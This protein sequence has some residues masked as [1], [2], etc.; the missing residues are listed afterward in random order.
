MKRN[1]EE[2]SSSDEDFGPVP[3]G[4]AGEQGSEKPPVKKVVCL[5]KHSEDEMRER[6]SERRARARE[7]VSV[8]L[9]IGG[10][11]SGCCVAY[12]VVQEEQGLCDLTDEAGA[13]CTV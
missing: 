6:E 12:L 3:Q 5:S 10:W 8:I 4:L 1:R 13:S 11:E 2:S 9:R 7:I